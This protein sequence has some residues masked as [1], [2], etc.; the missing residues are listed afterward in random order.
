M[1]TN[2]KINK[3][4]VTRFLRSPLF[5]L[6]T[7]LILVG[8]L[9]LIAQN[10]TES[11]QK[12]PDFGGMVTLRQADVGLN[13]STPKDLVLT[14]EMIL[15]HITDKAVLTGI[16][17]R[18]GWNVTYGEMLH[19]VDVKERLASQNSFI[20]YVNTGDVARSSKITRELTMSFLSDYKKRWRE[21]STVILESCQKRIDRYKKDLELLHGLKYK[22]HDNSDLQPANTELE[23][24]AVN[25][26]LVAAQGQFLNAYGAY[27]SAMESKRS[28]IQ[29][30]L[31]L[32][33]KMYT[34]S[35]RSVKNL[36]LQLEE[37]NRQCEALRKNL[38]EQKPELYKLSYEPKKLTGLPNDILYY[39]DNI[40]TLQQMR[41]GLMLGSLI[42]EKEKMLDS[43]MKNKNTIQRLLDSDSCDVFIREV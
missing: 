19:S 13:G 6:V 15:K 33:L 12:V 4:T 42:E 32:A 41:L 43:E 16:A 1:N 38:A 8:G 24:K 17:K 11:Y 35:D 29:I 9:Y 5:S 2:S 10:I 14:R 37:L 30:Q 3:K 27:I 28:D 22:F 25:E 18:N 39:Y 40:Q 31:D 21:R 23:M 36:K 26:Q 20:L 7:L 34:E